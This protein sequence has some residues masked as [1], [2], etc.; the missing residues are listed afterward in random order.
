MP[1]EMNG[2]ETSLAFRNGTV[3]LPDGTIQDGVVLCRD[4]RIE[5]VGAAAVTEIPPD[6]KEIDA[7]GGYLAPG[8]VDQHVHGALG[9]DFMDGTEEDVRL[10]IRGHT[11]YGTTSIFPTTTTGSPE[12]L[13]RMLDACEAVRAAWKPGDHA[14]LAGVHWYG[15]YFSTDKVGAH[16]DG[17]ERNPDPAE[18]LTAFER[19]IV[20]I[21]TCAAELPGA[22]AFFREAS[23]RGMLAT[24]GHSNASF[25]EMQR[26]FDAGLRH[27]DH[28]WCAM[29]S[30]T[31]IG[32]RLGTPYQGSMAEF[33]IMNEEMST[34]VLADGEHLAP[35]LLEFAYRLK[36][37]ERLCLV[38]DSNR[39]VDMPVGEYL[40][41]PKEAGKAF[42]HN[43]RV[44]VGSNGGLAST[45]FG[46]DHMMR[47]MLEQT[48]ASLTEVVRMASLTP[49]ERIGMDR[50]IGSLAPG[51]YADVLILD[52]DLNVQEVYV[53]GVP[54]TFFP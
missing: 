48:S 14:R 31:T 52:R 39:A 4:G 30:V 16:P 45:A 12:H 28:F 49:A 19:D 6:S 11:K 15:P 1:S 33:V 46:M 43:G 3:I 24:C 50:D 54:F 10:A 22:E 51:K 27:V 20:R 23:Q 7:G 42:H 2:T 40:I 47:T 36:G 37:P 35:E 34:E 18:Y 13:N 53:G 41:G 21:A 44:G 29:S 32:K 8:F 26:G 5:A 38:T 25:Q 9:A 17:F